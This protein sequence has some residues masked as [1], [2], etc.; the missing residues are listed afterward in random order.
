LDADIPCSED[1]DAV[2]TG[3]DAVEIEIPQDHDVAASGVDDDA[4]GAGNEDA[5]EAGRAIDRDRLR[6]RE[7]AEA[8][9]I[10]HVDLAGGGGL[11][12]R[13]GKGLTRGSA[14]AGIGVV[15]DAGNPGSSRLGFDERRETTNRGYH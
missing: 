3:A 14:A 8:A 1:Q 11:G 12:D 4:V 2:E 6:D 7:C 10:E 15:A 13:T 9:R 5:S